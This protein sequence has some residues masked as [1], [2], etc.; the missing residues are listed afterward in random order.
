MNIHETLYRIELTLRYGDPIIDR[1]KEFGCKWDGQARVWWVG[2]RHPNAQKIRH[3]IRDASARRLEMDREMERRR[4]AGHALSEP[5]I[6][7]ELVRTMGRIR[8]MRG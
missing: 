4:S 2:R 1:L 8:H 3:L 6:S 7:A 5:G